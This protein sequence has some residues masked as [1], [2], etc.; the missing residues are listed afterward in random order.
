MGWLNKLY[1]TH[2]T[3]NIIITKMRLTNKFNGIKKIK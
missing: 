3:G 1:N 2:A